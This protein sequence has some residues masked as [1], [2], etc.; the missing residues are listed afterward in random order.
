M[1]RIE[2]QEIIGHQGVNQGAPGL[3]QAHRD[4]PAAEALA[5]LGQP[6]AQHFG[7]LLQRA[8]FDFALADHLQAEGVFLIRPV[9]GQKGHKVLGGI[10]FGILLYYRFH[11]FASKTRWLILRKGLIERPA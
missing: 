1:D 6:G 8:G 11:W 5:Q 3:F 7:L 2:H 10:R 9:E 4:R